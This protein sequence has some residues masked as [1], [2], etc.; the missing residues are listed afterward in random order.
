MREL[1]YS[2]L[3]FVAK[4]LAVQD[5]SPDSIDGKLFAAIT[6]WMIDYENNTPKE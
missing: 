2:K 5:P 4:T 1:I 3:H 6:D